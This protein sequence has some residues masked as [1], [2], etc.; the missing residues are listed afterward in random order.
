[1]GGGGQGEMVGGEGMEMGYLHKMRKYCLKILNRKL[2]TKEKHKT[3][4]RYKAS[5]GKVVAI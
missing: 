4:K 3:V 1:M 2:K 5:P